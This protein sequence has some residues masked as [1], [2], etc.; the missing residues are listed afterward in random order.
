MKRIWI[1]VAL[2]VT[3]VLLGGCAAS[4]ETAEFSVAVDD[5]ADETL[6]N[7]SYEATATVSNDG[8]E[9]GAHSVDFVVDGETIATENVSLEPDETESV[10]FEHAF[11]ESGEYEVSVGE[12]ETSV[13]VLESPLSAVAEAMADLE[14]YETR[15]R[16]A[17]DLTTQSEYGQDAELLMDG[18]ATGRYDLTAETASLDRETDTE[19]LG[20][21]FNTLEEEWYED[22]TRYTRERDRSDTEYEYETESTTFDDVAVDYAF[23][24]AAVEDDPVEVSNGTVVYEAMIEDFDRLEALLD[25]DDVTPGEQDEESDEMEEAL[26]RV[27]VELGIDLSTARI[28]YMSAT[29]DVDGLQFDDD[30]SGDGEITFDVE[31]VAFDDPVDTTVP[32]EVVDATAGR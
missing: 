9:A 4:E 8:G 1:G 19:Y 26:E 31:F 12:A 23:P 27:T 13:T 14:T 6:V 17:M 11:E 32:A 2:V 28:D 30:M 21:E 24:L 3:I 10:T 25:D 22:G 29:Y 16:T 18:T 5:S 7:T 15:E 20:F